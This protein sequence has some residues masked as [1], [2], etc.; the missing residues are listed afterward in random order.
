MPLAI[1]NQGK[2]SCRKY[3]KYSFNERNNRTLMSKMLETFQFSVWGRAES[4]FLFFFC[5]IDGTGDRS[6]KVAVSD[7]NSP[8]SEGFSRRPTARKSIGASNFWRPNE[9]RRR[10]APPISSKVNRFGLLFSFFF[11]PD[12]QVNLEPSPISNHNAL[13]V[14]FPEETT[15]ISRIF[16]A[17]I[18]VYSS[19]LSIGNVASHDVTGCNFSST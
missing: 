1:E 16:A 5:A 11:P 3:W 10:P 7:R 13:Q 12:R 2:V 18:G 17:D 9:K 15:H 4:I 14:L 6:N 19:W 8:R